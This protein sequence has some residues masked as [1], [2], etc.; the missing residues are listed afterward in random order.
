MSWI[1]CDQ[2]KRIPLSTASPPEIIN[3]EHQGVIQEFNKI[4]ELGVK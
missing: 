2:N 4:N 1:K 3:M